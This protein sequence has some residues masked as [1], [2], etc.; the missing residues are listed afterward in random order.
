[1]KQY[2]Q[3][4]I[5]L[6]VDILPISTRSKN[7]RGLIKKG[8]LSIGDYTYQ[9]WLLKID[10]YHGS[11]AKVKIGKFCSISEGVR[12][13]TGG[14]HP[15]DWISTFPFRNQFNLPGKNLDGMPSTRGDVIIGND[16][17]IGTGVTILSGVNIGNGSIIA[18]GAIVTK[19]VPAYSIVAGIPAKVVRYRFSKEYIIFLEKLKWWDWNIDE[20]LKHVDI[21]S[22]NNIDSIKERWPNQV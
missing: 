22:S 11:E 16:V 5:N 8:W 7:L 10:V 2:L 15:V 9:W 12:I 19:D 13:I 14:I 3:K 4:I 17:W 20:I 1:M 21:L 6:L 18:T